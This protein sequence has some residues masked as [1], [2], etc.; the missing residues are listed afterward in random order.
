MGENTKY[1]SNLQKNS[2]VYQTMSQIEELRAFVTIVETGS[3]TQAADRLGIAVS[4][5]SRRLRDLELRLG[6][7]LIQRSTRRLYL[8]ETGQV[9]FERCKLILSDL[10]DAQQ[11]VSNAGGSLSGVLRVSAPLSFGLAHM[12]SAI[13]QFM[14]ANPEVRI[15]MDLSD[16]RVDLIAEGFDVAIRIGTLTDSSLIARKISNVRFLPAAAPLVVDQLPALSSPEDLQHLPALIYS[17]DRNPQDWHYTDQDGK[18]GVLRVKPIMSANNGDVL[19]E[20]AIAG[21]GMVNLPQFLHYEALNR[22]LLRP[23]FA[24][25]TWTNF[26]I[27]AV[28]PKT[29]ILP[30]RTRAFVDFMASL[31]GSNPYWHKLNPQ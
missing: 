3:L 17:N 28:Y 5:V 9:F 27:F 7:A 22:G 2:V 19:R 16:K 30:K 13:A 25:Y 1:N 8:N 26:D 29:T 20:L 15:E 4:A 10:E 18:T 21:H 14:H 31:Y 11:E 23:L 12:S 6:T 24:D